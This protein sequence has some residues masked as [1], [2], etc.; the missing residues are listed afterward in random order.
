MVSELYTLIVLTRVKCA[1]IQGRHNKAYELLDSLIE[2]TKICQG[3][4]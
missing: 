3:E 2:I 1:E 4:S